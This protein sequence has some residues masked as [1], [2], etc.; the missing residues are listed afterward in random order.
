MNQYIRLPKRVRYA[1]LTPFPS[2][3]FSV[4]LSP[5]AQ[6]SVI[7]IIIVPKFVRT[8]NPG[9]NI[10]QHFHES[11]GPLLTNHTAPNDATAANSE[12]D[13]F[14]PRFLRTERLAAPPPPL[15]IQNYCEQM[16][17][18]IYAAYPSRHQITTDTHPLQCST[19]FQGADR[20]SQPP[21]SLFACLEQKPESD[22]D[23]GMLFSSRLL[24]S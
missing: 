3:N 18:V 17:P 6:Q 23:W 13:Q 11:T 7:V 5:T 24:L 1:S 21:T 14:P 9:R 20:S 16:F 10:I 22:S 4:P 8:K 2:A 15:F 19:I 12:F